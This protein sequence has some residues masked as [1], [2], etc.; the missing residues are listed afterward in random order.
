LHY[1]L[2]AT[3]EQVL[4]KLA[5]LTLKM[6]T[7]EYERKRKTMSQDEIMVFLQNRAEQLDL[8]LYEIRKLKESLYQDNQLATRKHRE[9]KP[10]AVRH[11]W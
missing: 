10:G 6:T 3:F 7:E 5:V 9:W 2:Q 1:L 11:Q 4:S 8:P